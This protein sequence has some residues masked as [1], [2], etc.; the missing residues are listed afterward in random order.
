LTR[1]WLLLALAVSCLVALSVAALLAPAHLSAFD[2]PRANAPPS[3]LPPFGA[4]DRGRPL[5]DYVLQGTRIVAMPALLAG[6]LVCA[7][8]VLG[9]LLRAAGSERVDSWFATL[10]E[11]VGALPRMVV[12]LVVALVLPRDAHSMV[13]LALTWALLAAPGAMDEAAAV[14][15][16]LGGS[17]FVEALRAHGY[18]PFRIYGVHVVLLNLRPV[19]VRQ[20]AEVAMQVIFLEIA[21]SYLSRSA[22]QQSFTHADDLRSIADLLRLGYPSIVLGVPT[23]HALALG[24]GFVAITTVMTI[25][26][27]QAARAR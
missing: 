2:M 27:T 7:L 8:G 20:G 12:L 25:S 3:V 21:L 22:G 16:R 13:P 26:L 17:R 1:R 9:G 14:A 11:I 5:L 23:A 10:A 4:D 18:G 24:L 15:E 6:T 19:V